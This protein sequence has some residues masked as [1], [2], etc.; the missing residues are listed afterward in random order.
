MHILGKR[1]GLKLV[2]FPLRKLEKEEQ[3]KPKENRR[4][5][6]INIRDQ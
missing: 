4:K 5:E 6:I 1:K 2:K 3:F